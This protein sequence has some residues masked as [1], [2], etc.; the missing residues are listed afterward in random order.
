MKDVCCPRCGAPAITA[1]PRRGEG[2]PY[3]SVCGW[4]LERAKQKERVALKQTLFFLLCVGAVAALVTFASASG[5]LPKVFTSIWI[6]L[7][8]VGGVT[9]WRRLK[10]LESEPVGSSYSASSAT[11]T[12]PAAVVQN[13]IVFARIRTLSKPRNIKLKISSL[14]MC[15][16]CAAMLV[17]IIVSTYFYAVRARTVTPKLGSLNEIVDLLT[18]VLFI[19]IWLSITVPTIRGVFRDRRLLSNGEIGIAV[20]TRQSSTGG[21]SKTSRIEY[22]FQDVAGLQQT[23]K[24]TDESRELYED[25][26]TPVFYSPENPSENV[27]LVGAAYNLVDL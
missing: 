19:L 17:A 5:R 16:A 10:T 27:P 24:S 22:Q 4:N 12:P 23:G 9:A 2:K 13:R 8:V 26:E 3:C 21:K 11:L 20:V 18:F 1:S 15:G 25:M 7:V 14:F 6:G